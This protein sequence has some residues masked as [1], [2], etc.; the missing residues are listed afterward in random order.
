[1]KLLDLFCG[2]CGYGEGYH[3]S[4]YGGYNPNG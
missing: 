1:M 2:G 3:R 4:G